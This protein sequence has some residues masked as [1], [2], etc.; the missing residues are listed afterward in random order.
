M[1]ACAG[2]C[3][4]QWRHCWP[5]AAQ[6]AARMKHS[7]LPTLRTRAAASPPPSAPDA[8]IEAGR[9][10]FR[11]DTFGDETQWTDTLRMHEVIR[12]AVDPTTALSVGL[13]VD[14]E[15]LPP[16]VVEGHPGRQHQP[17]QPR[18]HGGTAQAQRGRRPEGHGR[19][20]RRQGHADAAS[21]S[22]ARCAT[23]PSTTRSR[24]ASASG[25]T[26][27]PIATSIPARSSPCRRR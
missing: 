26:A 1:P 20:R 8:A 27:G 2:A 17:D 13:K 21:A 23:R 10:I 5:D 25:S 19:D 22:P 15:A 9:Q 16:A 6:V 3:R 14:A 18:D 11:F 4:R 7:P 12:K 24:R